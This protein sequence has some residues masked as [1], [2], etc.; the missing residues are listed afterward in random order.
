MAQINQDNLYNLLQD[1]LNDQPEIETLDLNDQEIDDLGE[2]L[3]PL[4]QLQR[5]ND[6]NLSNNGFSSLP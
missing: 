2:I 6:I 3:Q 1:M 4:T 5:L